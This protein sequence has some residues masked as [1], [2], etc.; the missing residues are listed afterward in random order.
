M[1]ATSIFRRAVLSVGTVIL[2]GCASTTHYTPSPDRNFEPIPE[3]SSRSVVALQNAQLSGD[4]VLFIDAPLVKWHAHLKT[5]TDVAI[6]ITARELKK[7]GM[8]IETSGPKQ[9]R[10]SIESAK[11][12]TT[13]ATLETVIVMKVETGNGYLATYTGKNLCGFMC[14][15][16]NQVDGALMRVV[17]ELLSD[18]K[19]V[20]YLKN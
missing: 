20:E 14:A 2:S 1:R 17:V 15:V 13:F 10:L 16:G 9:L 12:N 4:S 8:G 18:P 6:A 11:R 3:F 19:I 7:R 5:W